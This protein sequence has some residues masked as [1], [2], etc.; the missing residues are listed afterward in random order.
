M[1]SFEKV[2]EE[3]LSQVSTQLK[4][5]NFV[6]CYFICSDL[7]KLSVTFSAKEHVLISEF[8]EYLFSNLKE[9]IDNYNIS[10]D[11]TDKITSQIDNFIEGLIPFL[12]GINTNPDLENE[13]INIYNHMRD[14]RYLV[15]DFQITSRVTKGQGRKP[16]FM[17]E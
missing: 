9:T 8:L 12:S 5:K 2:Y 11:T 15:T 7:T 10:E 1:D 14:I 4:K 16:R 3:K 13:K 6:G 17:F